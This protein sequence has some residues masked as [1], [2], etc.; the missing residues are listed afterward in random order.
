MNT[1]RGRATHESIRSIDARHIH[2][3]GVG[4]FGGFAVVIALGWLLWRL[5]FPVPNGGIVA[6]PPEPRLQPHPTLDLAVERRRETA[7]LDGYAWVDRRAGI[8]RIPI[9]R[10]MQI[11]ADKGA[12]PTSAS[13]PAPTTSVGAQR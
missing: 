6:I 13:M 8:A 1:P 2:W 3:A 9:A 4:F 12:P 7:T 5:S 10:A 11:L